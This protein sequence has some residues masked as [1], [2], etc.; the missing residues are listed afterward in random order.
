MREEQQQAPPFYRDC[1]QIEVTNHCNIKCHFC[2]NPVLKTKKGMM[3]LELFKKTINSAVEH[4]RVK[5]VNLVGIGESF[6]NP[7]IWEM[8][9]YC[10]EQGITCYVV[11]NMKWKLRE[12]NLPQ[13]MKL[14]HMHVTVDGVTNRVFHMSRPKTD[15][16]QIWSNLERI[17]E[18]KK[19]TNSPTPHVEVRMNIFKFNKHQL[20]DVLDQSIAI[21]ADSFWACKGCAT[22]ELETELSAEE[23]QKLRQYPADYI[24]TGGFAKSEGQAEVDEKTGL[25]Q[26]RYEKGPKNLMDQIGCAGPT[27]HWDGYLSPCCFDFE[28]TTKAGNLNNES[29]I[30]IW[31]PDRVESF[32]RMIIDGHEDR[33][34]CGEEIACDNCPQLNEYFG[35]QEQP[36]TQSTAFMFTERLIHPSSLSEVLRDI[37]KNRV[38]EA[39]TGLQQVLETEPT[40]TSAIHLLGLISYM[41]GNSERAVRLIDESIG[42]QTNNP[43]W[44]FHHNRA[45][46]LQANGKNEEALHDYQV[47][48]ELRKN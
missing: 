26:W 24:T 32:A 34:K 2:S 15:V 5:A 7:D 13:I 44:E 48:E 30:D 45:I 8:I 22:P 35:K 9:D 14:H 39:Y 4:P 10:H 38:Q 37:T 27:V 29:L 46:I 6:L 19:A 36:Q 31:Q 47:A 18:Y 3:T 28:N 11:S 1:L 23:W 42:H 16:Y 41:T 17:I 43:L 12:V 21:G 25:N 20:F 33:K 40:N